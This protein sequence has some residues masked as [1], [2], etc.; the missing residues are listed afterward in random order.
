MADKPDRT[1]LIAHAAAALADSPLAFGLG[2][3]LLFGL[4]LLA[5][6]WDGHLTDRRGCVQLQEM[7]GKVYKVDTCTGKVEEVKTTEETDKSST[8]SKK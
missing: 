2:F 3:G 4:P 8:S 1:S 7:K 6:H 5:T